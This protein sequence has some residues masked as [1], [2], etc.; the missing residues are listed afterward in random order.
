MVIADYEGNTINIEHS[1]YQ[2]LTLYI[3][4]KMMNLNKPITV[5]YN[6]KKI[7]KGKVVR[8]V[9]NLSQT[10]SER[11]DLRYMFPAKID[12]ELK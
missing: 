11:G 6:G 7:F 12:I 2:R 9:A 1:D 8:T 4:D 5:R 3:N 10:L